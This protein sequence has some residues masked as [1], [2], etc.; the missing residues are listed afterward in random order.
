[1]KKI[2]LSL[3]TF[4]G[5][6]NEYYNFK[7]AV[8]EAISQLDKAHIHSPQLSAHWASVWEARTELYNI[9]FED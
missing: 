4:N 8:Q 5:S 9:E 7:R 6:A 3:A 2:K 1:M